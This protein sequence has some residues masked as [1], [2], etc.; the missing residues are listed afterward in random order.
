MTTYVL[1]AGA[2]FHAGYPLASNLGEAVRDWIYRTKSVKDDSRIHIDQL[3][4]LY[5]GVGN[6]EE[7]LTDLDECLPGSRASTLPTHIRPYLLASFR[8]SIRE[9]FNDL[10]QRPAQLYKQLAHERVHPGDVIITF[11]YDLACER[12]LRQAALWEIGDGYG[13][14]LGLDAFPPSP[15]KILKLHGS[16]NWMGLLFGGRT[17]FAQVSSALGLRPSLFCRPDFDFLGYSN[18]VR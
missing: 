7:I 9:F 4:E 5:G 14:S 6:T 2:S 8:E 18:E 15:V 3:I 13:F 1:G 10:R 17:G 11:N 16:T 12:E